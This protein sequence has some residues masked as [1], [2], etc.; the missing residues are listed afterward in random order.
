MSLLPNLL[1]LA[2]MVL[3]L[4]LSYLR[5]ERFQYLERIQNYASDALD[6][7][8]NGG[9]CQE[10][11]EADYVRQ[12]LLFSGD[13][14]DAT[15]GQFPKF[16]GKV[17]SVLFCSSIDRI[18]SGIAIVI[19]AVLVILGSGHAVNR[20][21]TLTAFFDHEHIDVTLCLLVILFMFS[22]FLVLYGAHIDYKSRESI[23]N[24][25]KQTNIFLG[26]ETV[27]LK[28]EVGKSGQD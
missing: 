12:I 16:W 5:L 25:V 22:V 24:N 15:T 18:I 8:R 2:S 14:Q 4:G 7:L 20:F 23:D 6:S 28:E 26:Q 9:L 27:S 1:P 11:E 17:Y 19:S 3:A 13:I 21:Q 10:H